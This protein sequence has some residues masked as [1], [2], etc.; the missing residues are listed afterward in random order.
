VILRIDHLGLVAPSWSVARELLVEDYG[1]DPLY[2]E[3]HP[4]GVFYEPQNTRNHFVSLGAETV[5][6]VLVPQ[7]GTSGVARFL[8][9]R[10]PGLHHVAYACDDVGAQA[11]ALAARG[12]EPL[13]DP[14]TLAPDDVVF[15]RPASALGVLTELVPEGPRHAGPKRERLD[16]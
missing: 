1:F 13:Q 4:E 7:D 12:L 5:I 2:V 10:G 14:S 11:R 9:R 16:W 15:L 8:A 6:E 3:Q